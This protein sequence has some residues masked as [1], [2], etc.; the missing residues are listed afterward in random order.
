MLFSSEGRASLTRVPGLKDWRAA[1]RDTATHSCDTCPRVAPQEPAGT[2]RQGHGLEPVLS[3]CLFPCHFYSLLLISTYL[4]SAV[5]HIEAFTKSPEHLA[6][7]F[8]SRIGSI[9]NN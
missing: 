7:T 3:H 1:R 5:S 8:R 6:A 9:M 2:P 4:L